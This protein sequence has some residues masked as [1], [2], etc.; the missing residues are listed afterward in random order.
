M[1]KAKRA[2][3]HKGSNKYKATPKKIVA[4]QQAVRM[5][6]IAELNEEISA[7]KRQYIRRNFRRKCFSFTEAERRGMSVC[8]W[9]TEIDWFN[10]HAAEFIQIFEDA[11]K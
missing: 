1:S 6:K 5:R 9:K 2:S 11:R 3:K 10:S 4:R 7:E 8:N